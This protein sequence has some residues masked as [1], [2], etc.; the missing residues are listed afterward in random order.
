M[1]LVSAGRMVR[2]SGA[3]PGDKVF[4]TGTIGDAALGLAALTGKLDLPADDHA[5]LADRYRLPQPRTA[6]APAIAELAHAALD[7]S[8]GLAADFGHLCRASGVAGEIRV[9]AVPLSGPARHILAADPARLYDVLTG[10]DDYE[11]LLV[12]PPG[13]A[14]ALAEAARVYGIPICEIGI[15]AA[16]GGTVTVIGSDGRPLALDRTGWTHY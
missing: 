5:I 10:G 12:A 6:L 7:V 4:V 8:D 9:S 16:G 3:R 13:S 15:I 11:I 14:N 1:G 2:R